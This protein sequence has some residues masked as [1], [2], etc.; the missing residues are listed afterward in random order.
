VTTD[1]DEIRQEI[2]D[3]QQRLSGDVDALADKVSP[4]RMV[5]RRAERARTAMTSVKDRLMGSTGD[6]AYTAR[7]TV[8]AKAATAKDA[9]GSAV[10]GARDS[11]G[12]AASNAAD[13]LGSAPRLARERAQGNPLAVGLIAFGAGW[14]VS[15]LLPA[16]PP[17]KQ[18]ASQVK[19]TV[20]EKGR[21]VAQQ[22]GQAAQEAAQELREPAMQ[23]AQA[24]KETASDAA[25]DVS[26][27]ARSAAGDVAGQAR[28][29]KDTVTGQAR[30]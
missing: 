24:V 11:M 15:S 30:S 19:N 28:E 29:A 9:V 26:E 21:P 10:S 8:G 25:T 3:T 14:L 13:A 6:S 23:A 7:D 5:Q 4:Q 1:P 22:L 27:H 18:L 2:R 16:S 12:S 17:E 20:T